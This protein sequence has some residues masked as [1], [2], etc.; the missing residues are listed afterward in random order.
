MAKLADG[1][2]TVY[3]HTAPNGKVYI[4]ITS[5]DPKFRWHGGNGYYRNEH[6]YN[7]IKKYGWDNITH[8]IIETDLPKDAACE[9]E[10]RLITQ[11]NATNPKYGYNGTHGGEHYKPTAEA[12]EKARK[13]HIGKRY[14]I[15]VP[16]TEE[17]KRHLRENHADFRGEKNPNYG[18]K[19]TPE[20]IAIRQAHRKYKY[21]GENPR[22]K[23]ILQFDRNGNF[24]KRWNSIT[25]ATI[26]CNKTSIK[27]CLKGKYKVGGGFV[28]KYD[29]EVKENAYQG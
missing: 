18:K 6:F 29:N 8:E 15:G 14:N 2:F 4:G 16:F 27:D 19:W 23:P 13:A 7:A 5:N 10:I 11:Y 3:K 25:D 17:R 21:G 9:L 12:I 28:W 26:V 1:G 20:Q 22:S 24:I